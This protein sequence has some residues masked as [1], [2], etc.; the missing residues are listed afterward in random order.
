MRLLENRRAQAQH[1]DPYG[2]WLDYAPFVDEVRAFMA[3]RTW[4]A[5]SLNDLAACPYGFFA[6]YILK[7]SPYEEPQAGLTILQR[8]TL[9]HAILQEAYTLIQTEGLTINPAHQ[10]RAKALARQAAE[11]VLAD[12]PAK[13][14]LPHYALWEQ[15]KADLTQS[16]ESAVSADFSADS[17]IEKALPNGLAGKTRRPWRQELHFGD[18]SISVSLPDPTGQRGELRLHGSIDRVDK[19]GD[20]LLILDY[21]SGTAIPTPKQLEAG[22]NFQMLVYLQAARTLFP[23]VQDFIGLFFSLQ[24]RKASQAFDQASLGKAQAALSALFSKVEAAR[25]GAFPNW[26]AKLGGGKCRS[27]CPYWRLCRPQKTP[28][29]N[30]FDHEDNN[31]V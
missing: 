12:A 27:H 19:I 13:Y 15:E 2:G 30:H 1:G 25:A 24:S 4:S 18:K 23:E 8:G 11:R 5:T 10:D 29:D 3:E 14:G 17:P 6:K 31:H 22:E 16:A 7:L 9:Y 21:K 20:S 28:N 26:P